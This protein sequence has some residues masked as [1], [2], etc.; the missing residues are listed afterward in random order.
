MN[1]LTIIKIGGKLL[2]DELALNHAITSFSKI[3]TKKIL[4][5]GGGKRASELC[6]KLGIEP[7]M[8][9]GRRIT[10]Q[11]TLEVVTMVYAGLINK[12]LVS[13]LQHEDC[14]AIGF[15]G[16]DGNLITAQKRPPKEIDYGF[17]G[18]VENVNTELLINLLEQGIVPVFCAITHDKNGQ[19]LNTNADTIASVL[20]SKLSSY[21]Q[22]ILKFCF[23]KE[24]VLADPLNERSVIPLLSK[25]DYVRHQQNGT[26]SDGMIPKLD[27]AFDAKKSNIHKVMICGTN[28]ILEQ[29]GTE[30]CL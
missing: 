9:N 27:N 11:A 13:Y 17:V 30:I 28:G 29:K 8:N 4:V 5:H 10:D 1:P 12:K 19:L 14:N 25:T 2:D 21:F 6:L 3:S 7:Q 23:E 22:I 20:A 24:G 18:N 15:S 26:I 16:A